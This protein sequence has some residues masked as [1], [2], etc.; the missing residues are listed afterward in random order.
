MLLHSVIKI[1][2]IADPEG[3][4]LIILV[5]R[6]QENMAT[7]LLRFWI[8]YWLSTAK[9]VS[10]AKWTCIGTQNRS[11]ISRGRGG[12]LYSEVPKWISLNSYPVLTTRCHYQEVWSITD[13]AGA[14]REK[15]YA[16][17]VLATCK[18][19]PL[20]MNRMTDRHLNITFTQLRWQPVK[21]YEPTHNGTVTTVMWK[22]L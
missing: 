17:L 10:L 13:E 21:I 9:M 20:P 8:R 5:K 19:P 14:C 15:S 16:S 4:H 7:L 6:G 11:A 3:T 1:C 12:G 18:P 22:N 2:T